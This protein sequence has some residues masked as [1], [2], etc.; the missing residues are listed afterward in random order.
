M[1][2]LLLLNSSFLQRIERSFQ[3]TNS[4]CDSLSFVQVTIFLWK[5]IFYMFHILFDWKLFPKDNFL[6]LHKRQTMSQFLVIQQYNFKLFLH[7]CR[8]I[9]DENIILA[10]FRLSLTKYMAGSGGG[11][12][13]LV[14]KYKVLCFQIIFNFT[15]LLHCTF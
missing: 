14:V 11:G 1:I 6:T 3:Y 12:W 4:Q 5:G 9:F 13:S 8:L 7:R 10:L 15:D 2:Q